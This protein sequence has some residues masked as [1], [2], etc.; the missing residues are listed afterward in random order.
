METVGNAMPEYARDRQPHC[1]K[2]VY[3]FVKKQKYYY[4]QD[5]VRVPYTKPIN[6]W[7]GEIMKPKGKSS[8]DEGTGQNTYRERNMRPNSSGANAPDV[9]LINTKPFPRAHFAVFPTRL[10]EFLI[11]VGCPEEGIVLDPFWEAGLLL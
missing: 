7:G 9:V 4:D 8:W 5:A 10:V 11:K 3:H 2:Y 6:R 1:W